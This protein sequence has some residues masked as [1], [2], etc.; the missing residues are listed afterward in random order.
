MRSW[1]SRRVGQGFASRIDSL[2]GITERNYENEGH[3]EASVA[4][5]YWSHLPG[6]KRVLDLGCAFGDLGRCK[7]DGVEVYGL[8]LNPALVAQAQQNEIAQVWDLEQPTPLPFPDAYFDA[9][10]AKD[11]LEHLQKPWRTVAEIHRLLR[12]GGLVL[13]SVPLPRGH[14]VWDD[15]THVRGFTE[16]A[17]SQM[18]T[19]AGFEVIAL[20][21]MGGVPL[22]ARLNLIRLVPWLLR[23]SP[24]DWAYASSYEIKVRRID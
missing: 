6:A 2:A 10:V 14:R 19:D 1:G 21:K 12:P 4:R 3:I 20:W 9:V 8:E 5:F 22:T 7:P 11:L 18:F 15:Y 17:L 13:A 23:I 24:L 16:R